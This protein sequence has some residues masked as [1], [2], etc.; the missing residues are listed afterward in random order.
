M[1]LVALA[2]PVFAADNAQQV[3]DTRYEDNFITALSAPY[4]QKFNSCSCI[5][6]SKWYLGRQDEFWGNANT[7]KP[8]HDYPNVGDV[9]LTNEGIYG[10]AGVVKSI[11]DGKILI[12]ESNYIPCQVSERWLNID[13]PLIRGYK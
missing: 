9:V 11:R 10:H 4:Y 6:Y 1:T 8:T 5:S 13:S 3:I 12:A 2:W 7:I